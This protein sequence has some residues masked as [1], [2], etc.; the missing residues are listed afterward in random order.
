MSR[1]EHVLHVGTAIQQAA[2]TSTPAGLY[3]REKLPEDVISTILEQVVE[4]TPVE[5]LCSTVRAR[6][7][8]LYGSGNCPPDETVW[9]SVCQRMGLTPQAGFAPLG[10]WQGTFHAFCTQLGNLYEKTFHD[11][12]RLCMRGHAD[13]VPYE[14][15]MWFLYAGG[16]IPDHPEVAAVEVRARHARWRQVAPLP[17][18][19]LEHHGVLDLYPEG[20]NDA[21]RNGQQN[22]ID[23]LLGGRPSRGLQAMIWGIDEGER[24]GWEVTAL[25]LRAGVNPNSRVTTNQTLLQYAVTRRNPSSLFV[26]EQ[27]LRF[28]ADKNVKNDA[29]KTPVEVVTSD[30]F[31]I[32]RQR[33]EYFLRGNVTLR[34]D[35]TLFA[36]MHAWRALDWWASHDFETSTTQEQVNVAM[37]SQ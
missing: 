2:P 30:L 31:R 36:L 29:G 15:R 5:E 28:G 26:V 3:P 17:I 12:I 10:T 34:N 1:L 24:V 20:L 7:L 27:L 37:R 21:V 13:L 19:L 33:E 8:L 22:A 35:Y 14:D 9:S 32:I 23:L 16:R 4:G 6:C 25:L 11:A 18:Q